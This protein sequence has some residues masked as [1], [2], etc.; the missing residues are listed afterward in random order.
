M[1]FEELTRVM[2]SSMDFFELRRTAARYG[3]AFQGIRRSKLLKDLE[4]KIL[5]KDA[6][7][8]TSTAVE[9]PKAVTKVKSVK[10]AAELRRGA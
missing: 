5:C 2:L 1:T 6:A 7:T 9:T 3:V 10:T 4:K 8:T